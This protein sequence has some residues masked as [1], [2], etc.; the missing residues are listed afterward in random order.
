MDTM[1]E[2]A[3]PWKMSGLSIKYVPV[4]GEDLLCAGAPAQNDLTWNCDTSTETTR[5]H[6]PKQQ[7]CPRSATNHNSNGPQPPFAG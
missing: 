1:W 7:K 6:E 2:E 3:L 4:L 5:H